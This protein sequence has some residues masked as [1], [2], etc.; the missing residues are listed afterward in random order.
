MAAGVTTPNLTSTPVSDEVVVNRDGTTMLQKTEDLAQQV[1]TADRT[2]S[3]LAR[4]GA[5]AALAAA[6]A[7]LE[8]MNLPQISAPDARKALRV[9]PDGTGY[10]LGDR[11]VE[12][13]LALSQSNFARTMPFTWEGPIPDNLFIWDGGVNGVIGSQFRPVSAAFANQMRLP[14]AYAARLAAER[15]ETDFY[16]VICATGGVGVRSAV[17]VRFNWAT[18]LAGDPGTGRIGL[19]HATPGSATRVRYSETDAEGWVRF[20]AG[21]SLGV[22][23]TLPCRIEVASNP[24]AYVEIMPGAVTDEGA[25]RTQPVTVS[26]SA[27]WP[28]PDGTPVNVYQATDWLREII[29]AN[30]EAALTW[31]GLTGD[32]RRFDR[33]FLWP[34]ESDVAYADS[35]VQR[36]FPALLDYLGTWADAGTQYLH[37]LP[38]PHTTISVAGVRRWWALLKAALA[39]RSGRSTLID[40]SASPISAWEPTEGDHVHVNTGA[41]MMVIGRMI[42]DSERIGGITLV[43]GPDGYWAPTVTMVSNLDAA[44]VTGRGMISM[45]GLVGSGAVRLNVDPLTN[46]AQTTLKLSA[47]PGVVFRN[48]TDVIGQCASSVRAFIGNVSA[49]PVDNTIVVTFTAESTVSHQLWVNFNVILP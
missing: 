35:Y 30:S 23:A 39:Q 31:L 42:R 10:R 32:A 11:T 18:S 33:M 5:E 19:N 6:L 49:D 12:T 13:I 22:S 4:L 41:D 7:V 29:R 46:A 2:A 48:A 17:G 20:I 45:P 3:E 43:P 26:A 47:P 1:A 40:L 44:S 25:Y 24:A 9:K 34:T 14:V 27:S 38:W 37:T 28:P 36:D 8:S 15:P 16:L 21:T